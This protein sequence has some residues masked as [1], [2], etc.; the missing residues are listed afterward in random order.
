MKTFIQ[1]IADTI[2]N[3]QSSWENLTVIFPNRRAA[4]YFRRELAKDLSSPQ[5]S[6]AVLTIEE[7]IEN[8]SSLREID[9]LS[10]VMRLFKTFQRV[11]GSQETIDQFYYW[12]EMLLR[13]F[14]ELDKN[15]VN[16]EMLF[17]DLRNQKELDSYFDYL[18]EEQKKYLLDFWQSLD[19]ATSENKKSFLAMWERLYPVYSEFKR[20]LLN[21][22]LAYAGMIHRA[23]AESIE[24]LFP[25][26]ATSS[27]DGS[28][29]FAGFNALT[30]AEEKII[31]WIV[32]NRKAKVFWDEDEFYVGAEQREAGTFFRQY[33]KHPV[34]GPTFPITPPANL[35][36]EKKI[37]VIGVPQKAG[38][39]K[40]LSQQLEE[41][42]QSASATGNELSNETVIVLPDESLLTSVLYSLPLSVKAINVS[43]GYSLVNTPYY[44]LID[45]LF[46]L[47]LH[48]RKDDFYHRYVLAILNH[49]YIISHVGLDSSSLQSLIVAK[50]I[51][52]V[53]PS[54][55][56][57]RNEL[58]QHI[59]KVVDNKDFIS[60]LLDVIEL[61][62]K[63]FA[64]KNLETEFAFHFHRMLSRFQE[65]APEI[66]DIQMI[67]RLFRQMARS[68][69]VPF[70]GEP[71][72]GIQI[73]GILETRNLDFENV[74]VL[75]LNEGLWPASARQ[76]S[77]IP[78]N[79]RRAYAL[80]T[81]Q[82]QDAMYAYLFYRLLHR[83]SYVELYYNTEPDV[84]GAGE[85]SRYLY[86]IMYE[87][88]WK[89]DHKIL[90]NKIELPSSLPI[91]IKKNS[92]VLERINRYLT[93][94]LTPST[95]NSY[96]ECRLR[97]YFKHLIGLKEAEEVEEAADARMFGNIF[98]DSL[99][100]FYAAHKP[101]EGLWQIK[102]EYFN[103][104]DEK[105]EALIEREFIRQFNLQDGKKMEY[106]GHQLIVKAMVKKMA[107]RVLQIDR[108]YAPFEIVMLEESNFKT[109]VTIFQQGKEIRILIGGKI[110]RVDVKDN[111]VR[112][113]DYKT[114]GDE[115]S[116]KSIASLFDRTKKR[117]KAA[118]QAILYGWVYAKQD[119]LLYQKLQ[120]GLINRKEIF[121]DDYK[122]GLMMD[123][124]L[125]YDVAPLLPEFEQHLIQLLTELFDPEQPFDQTDRTENCEYCSFKGICNR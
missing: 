87:T 63:P 89:Y 36:K 82:H 68:E 81:A 79:I 26:D 9:K 117:N 119:E 14:D 85:M 74:I 86:Q 47:H 1:E 105:L 35:Y 66:T 75:S 21:D 30:N 93:R 65:V 19:P 88:G 10:L 118:F 102:E 31:S 84:T 104:L 42:I 4:I 101:T 77:Y 57:N 5:W 122:Y 45:Y 109:G 38:Q 7:F 40:I 115:N 53:S 43:M 121:K 37:N 48:K 28:I 124:E 8:H 58:L 97:F 6:P 123:K 54:L 95:L 15:L 78:H 113:I 2:R 13:D 25:L 61:L 32:K 59:F 39:S 92:A 69:K 23:V 125:L 112:I 34:L 12:G 76:G 91:T 20:E 108:S 94:E 22:K 11:T 120:P 33:R 64:N 96:V 62:T 90:Y 17:R 60:F 3:K 70:E 72:K 83:A 44:S 114:G 24:S 116:F 71:M 27:Q 103:N 49:P 107:E 99:E 98:H 67:Q 18:S 46:D 56:E 111:I 16:A 29:I 41:A 55:F 106:E 50:N 110:D 52:Y 73:M 80:P 51:V 100:A